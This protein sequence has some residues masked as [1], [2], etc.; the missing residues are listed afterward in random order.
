MPTLLADKYASWEQEAN[1]RF[2]QLKA[3]EEELNRIVIDIY[4]LQDEL[5]PEVEDKD[6]TVRKACLEREIKS[7]ISYAIG[8][9]FGRYSLDED[10]LI[11][12]G[13]EWDSSRYKTFHPDANNIIPILD[14][15]WFEDDAV[16]QLKH[17]LGVVYGTDTLDENTRF[18]EQALGKD[19]RSYL[20]KDFYDNHIKIYQKRP[21]YWLFSSPKKSFNVLVYLHRY[22][23]NT[24]SEIL[25]KY[26]R[27]F[28]DKLNIRIQS[29]RTTNSAKDTAEA[30]KLAAVINELDNWERDVI[31]PMANEHIHIA[32]DDGVKVNYNKFPKALRK[33]PGLTEW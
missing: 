26:L 3:N 1:T 6:V 11:Y 25:S 18:I 29:L 12:A 19:I 2:S 4:G 7:L 31:Y 17:W 21:I 28:R 10:G 14:A 30:E 15:E 13:G 20:V 33:I 9:M 8:C 23:E 22:T 16:S 32:L 5:T 24:V 27:P